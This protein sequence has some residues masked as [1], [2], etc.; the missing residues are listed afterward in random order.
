MKNIQRCSRYVYPMMSSLNG[1]R[2]TDG[3]IT[4]IFLGDRGRNHRKCWCVFRDYVV[5]RMV[6]EETMQEVKENDII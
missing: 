2:E 3:I 6:V 1:W 5:E 4:H